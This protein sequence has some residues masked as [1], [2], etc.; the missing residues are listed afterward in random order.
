MT[1]FRSRTVLGVAVMTIWCVAVQAADGSLTYTNLEERAIF[2]ATLDGD[3]VVSAEPAGLPSG[4]HAFPAPNGSY[5][6]FD[7]ASPDSEGQRDIFVTFRD[8]NG[9]WR[10]AVPLGPEVNTGHSETCPSLSPDGR[11]LFFSR[12]NEPGGLSNIYWVSSDVITEVVPAV[13]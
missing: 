7:S 13:E 10:P 11:F 12:Y 5:T 8:D 2:R 9:T 3:R 6:V 1:P 4:G